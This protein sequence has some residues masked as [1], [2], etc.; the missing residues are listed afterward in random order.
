MQK[1]L[2]ITGGTSGIG[3]ACVERYG[4]SHFNVVFTGRDEHKTQQAAEGFRKLGISC[5]GISAA[6]ED[7]KAAQIVIQKTIDTYG[8][9]DVLICNAGVSMK[10]LFEDVDLQVFDQVMKV[11]FTGTINYVKYALPHVIQS[12][13]SIVGISSINGHRGTPGRTAYSA[14]KFAMEGFFEALRIEV[15]KRGVHIMTMSPGYTRSNIRTNALSADGSV[16][17]ESHKNESK[18]MEPETV[19]DHIYRA[20]MR[21]KRNVILTLLGKALI[22]LNK[23]FPRWMDRTVYNVMTKEDPSLIKH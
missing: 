23:R 17:N 3:K 5:L 16:Q 6:V 12:K 11:N 9:I 13:G 20:Q 18:L 19:A 8:S 10:A 1:T 14:S 4:K 7:E 22:F 2:L 21:R 15:M